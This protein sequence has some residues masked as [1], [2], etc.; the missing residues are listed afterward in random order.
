MILGKEFPMHIVH[1]HIHVKPEFIEEFKSISM[2][3]ARNSLHESGIAR[4]DVIQQAD[5]PSR[6]EL[7]EVYHTPADPSKH[8]ETA[9]Y[10]KWRELAEPMLVEPRTRTLFVNVFPADKEW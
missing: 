5:D 7:I 6:F 2:E 8:K 3:N 9:H 1:V 10:N 4:F